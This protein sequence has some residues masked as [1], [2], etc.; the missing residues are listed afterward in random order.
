VQSEK[1]LVSIA[2]DARVIRV[3]VDCIDSK[4]HR[5]SLAICSKA[6]LNYRSKK[7]LPPVQIGMRKDRLETTSIRERC[8]LGFA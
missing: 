5:F 4:C 1:L 2:L 7:I 3:D 8:V 6:F